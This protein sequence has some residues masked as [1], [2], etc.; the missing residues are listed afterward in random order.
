M[1]HTDL[2]FLF[3]IF[4]SNG[5]MNPRGLSKRWVCLSQKRPKWPFLKTNKI[6]V[7]ISLIQ[8]V[9]IS[10]SLDW[11]STK[12]LTLIPQV[13]FF[14][15]A[16]SGI[17]KNARQMETAGAVGFLETL[18]ATSVNDWT[19]SSLNSGAGLCNGLG[20]F[21][22]RENFIICLSG[23]LL[24]YYIAHSELKSWFYLVK[25]FYMPL[26][27]TK[28]SVTGA[29]FDAI[30]VEFQGVPPKSLPYW[31][32]QNVSLQPFVYSL[33]F[34]NFYFWSTSHLLI[35]KKRK[36]RRLRGGG[37]RQIYGGIFD[38]INLNILSSCRT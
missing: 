29:S 33:F 15:G 18:N 30:S 35:D 1:R 11:I 12:R 23:S 28:S 4:L 36:K 25:D 27:S 16:G 26:L 13:F 9:S 34:H 38:S 14:F 3:F 37:P 21:E 8:S 7:T 19:K 5:H 2:C 6:F 20:D 24:P 32:F 31:I 10:Y 22:S 17:L